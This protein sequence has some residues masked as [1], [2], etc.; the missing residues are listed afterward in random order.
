M[1]FLEEKTKG[2]IKRWVVIRRPYILIFKD[3]KDL[4]CIQYPNQG[5][6]LLKKDKIEKTEKR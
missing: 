1:N 4:V 2:W 6:R 3:E 5:C